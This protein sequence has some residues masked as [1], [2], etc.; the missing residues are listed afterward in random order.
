M[1]HQIMQFA[2]KH[3]QLVSGFIIIAILIVLEEATTQRQKGP[4][5]TSSGVTHAINRDNALVIDLREPALF[6]EG[7]IVGSK[8][9]PLSEFDR[10]EEKLKSHIDRHIILVDAMGLKT[11]P[12]ALRLKKA[13]FLKIASLKGGIDAWKMANM[14]VTKK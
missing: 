2:I 8:N 4:Q 3:W 7:H 6:R 10:Q 9:F 1:V 11:G 5:L 14:P 12:I 13:G